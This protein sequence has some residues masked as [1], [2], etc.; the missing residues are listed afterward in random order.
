MNASVDG[1]NTR[2]GTELLG[3][4]TM[5]RRHDLFGFC[6]E[7][8]TMNFRRNKR[9]VRSLLLFGACA[10][11]AR[12]VLQQT[13][14]ANLDI[15]SV[16]PSG[17]MIYLESQDFLGQL[18]RWDNSSVKQRWLASENFSQ[19]QKSRLYLRLSDKL[20]EFTNLVGL[21]VDFPLVRSLAGRQAGLGLYGIR[22]LEF[23]FVTRVPG[24]SFEQGSFFRQ[25][26][27]YE[28]RS[29]EGGAYFARS[30][31]SSAIA[32]A[33]RNNY[34]F[35]A[36]NENLLRATLHNLGVI[37]S[38]ERL[39]AERLFQETQASLPRGQD[40][41]MYINMGLV[42]DSRYFRNEWLYK[43]FKETAGY[44]A[45]AVRLS[46]EAGQYREERQFLLKEQV[47]DVR[48]L[49]QGLVQGLPGD[50][51]FVKAEA[52]SSRPVAEAVHE[53]LLNS[54]RRRDQTLS[55]TGREAAYEIAPLL[56]SDNRYFLQIDEPVPA[57]E[58]VLEAQRREQETMV[59]ELEKELQSLGVVDL[60]RCASPALDGQGYL[61]GR[62]AF[63]LKGG[64][65][66][67][68]SLKQ[69]L[70]RQY[71]RLHHAGA[72]AVW[73]RSE[74]GLE[75]LGESP[76]MAL[77]SKGQWLVL[78]TPAEFVRAIVTAAPRDSAIPTRSLHYYS[79][80]DVKQLRPGYNALFQSLD[81]QAHPRNPGEPSPFFSGN[82]GSLLAALSPVESVTV[83]RWIQ[84][85]IRYE[86]VIYR[87]QL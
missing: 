8:M 65:K 4:G 39:S 6:K 22:D 18:Q 81:Y 55:L 52:A 24:S 16:L 64:D 13:G 53:T 47:G 32:F 27:Q 68:S 50:L 75:L 73:S 25:R 15:A 59:A 33:I 37:A 14:S 30:G 86:E 35:L 41:W 19:F 60:V 10:L 70:Q 67:S 9:R 48:N 34:F 11:L 49:E 72:S 46:L 84:G 44:R 79:H 29:A 21:T 74:G 56:K 62:Q 3:A 83:Q 58:N 1:L 28:Q 5:E 2:G 38:Q 23:V 54:L 82:L 63:V 78:G 66:D 26:S 42:Q 43:N 85:Q 87:G 77:A 7:W 40:L 76:G 17:A 45:G 71:N 61:R 20:Q 51:E 12:P 36:T 69:T 80:L 31:Q 57:V